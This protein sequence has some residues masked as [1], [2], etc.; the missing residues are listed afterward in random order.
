MKFK[1][2]FSIFFLA[3]SSLLTA[4]NFGISNIQQPTCF[5]ACDGSITYT[6]SSL[7]GPFNAVLTNSASCSNSTLS[8]SS[9]TAITISN[10]CACASDYTISIYSGTIIAGVDYVQFPNFANAPLSVVATSIIAASCATCCNGQ[11][12]ISWNG[13]NTTFS[14]TP[15]AFTLDGTPTTS[16]SPTQPLCVGQHTICATDSSQCTACKVF[17]VSFNLT[18]GVTAEEKSE[19]MAVYPNPAVNDLTV[20]ASEGNALIQALI[21]DLTGRIVYMSKYEIPETRILIFVGDLTPGLYYLEVT[22]QNKQSVKR[23]RFVKSDN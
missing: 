12:Y 13:G 2:I 16:Y 9:A 1:L 5:G 11:A 19:L 14:N 7:T 15:P 17:S 18:T 10:I 3:F 22:G 6:T 23:I 21:Y 8:S 20:E 4:Q